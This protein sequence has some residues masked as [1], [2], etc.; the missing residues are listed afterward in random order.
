MNFIDFTQY[1]SFMDCP[2]KWYERFVNQVEPRREARQRDDTQ[3][4]GKLVHSGLEGWGR[5]REPR[6]S[7]AAIEEATPTP[8]CLETAQGLVYAYTQ[9]Y[10]SEEWDFRRE[11]EP[12][13][14]SIDVTG[15][16]GLAKIDRYFYVPELTE[17][18]GGLNGEKLTLSPGWWIHEYKTKDAGISRPNW[19]MGWESGM[20]ADFQLLAL[21]ENVRGPVQ[22]VI[23]QVIEKP[24][25]YV[26]KRKCKG[27]E[28]TVEMS[29]WAAVRGGKSGCPWCGNV[30]ELKAYEAKS[31]RVTT[32]YRI[33]VTRTNER[34]ARA[35]EE[36]RQ[37]ACTMEYLK[38]NGMTAVPNRTACVDT[39]FGPCAYF[40]NHTYELATGEDS[41]MV[42]TNAMK[43]IGLKEV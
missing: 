21:G 38:G 26:P 19:M 8:E 2:W 23:V 22:G 40:N 9:R 28:K 35:L 12:L 25:T 20:Q 13:T 14:F 15:W 11:E 43:Y 31:E 39:I 3:T 41:R 5:N 1:A 6:I 42:K 30:Q 27:C 16:M 18:E 7:S 17:V 24:R 33:V 36:I 4:L 34:L 29:A 37:V 32:F 10:P